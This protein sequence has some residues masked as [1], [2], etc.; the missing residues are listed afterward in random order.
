[1]SRLAEILEEIAT[2]PEFST[3][4]VGISISGILGNF[5]IHAAPQIANNDGVSPMEV[6]AQF[7]FEDIVQVLKGHVEE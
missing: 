7:G 5:P 2:R 6:A 4:Q 1:M 3:K